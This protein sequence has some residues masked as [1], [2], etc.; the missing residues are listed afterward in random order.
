MVSKTIYQALEDK[1]NPDSIKNDGP[2]LCERDN[3]W[4][5]TGYYFWESFIENAH[6]W[7][8]EGAN[9]SNGYVICKAQYDFD[10]DHCF[11]LIDNLNHLNLLKE[12]YKLLKNN[13]LANK[14]TTVKRIIT[15]LKDKRGIFRY[16][17]TRVY[18]IHSKNK[19][20]DFMDFFPFINGHIA[21]L[22]ATPAIQICFYNKK[23]LNFRDYHIVFPDKYIEDYAI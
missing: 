18:G 2:F 12:T 5:G 7:G 14:R 17:A 6:W 16:K 21:Y 13:G 15:Y 23:A 20:S 10:E 11:N 4:L 22:D 9:Y 1:N 8:R 3:S 19:K